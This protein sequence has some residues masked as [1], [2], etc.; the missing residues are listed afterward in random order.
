V[1]DEELRAGSGETLFVFPGAGGAARELAG[2]ARVLSGDPRVIALVPLPAPDD[3]GALTTVEAMATTA[4]ALIRSHQPRGPYRLLGYSLGGIVALEAGQRL[5]E[6]GEVVSF[7]GLVDALYD[8]RYWPGTLFIRASA[9][10]SA[11]HVRGLFGKPP[12]HAWHE[13]RERGG[14]LGVRL[15]GRFNDQ[16]IDDN[17]PGLTVQ[18]ANLV[19]MSRWRPRVFEG[20]IVFFTADDTDFGCDLADV[21]RPWLPGMQVR[22]I[23]GKH[24]DLVHDPGGMDRLAKTV[25]E[26]L[27]ASTTPRLH[28]LVATTFR[29]S[30]AARLAVELSAAGCKVE[31]VAPRGS[32]L[33]KIA[34]V[35]GSYALGLIDAA[36][37]L[38][39][40]IESSSADLI[41]PFD[42]RT[43]R[44]L[45]RVYADADP[46][47][48]AGARLRGRLERSLGPP[49]L[50]PRLYS[51]V[52]I[53]DIAAECGLRCPPTAAVRSAADVT[54]WL[55]RHPGPAVLKTDGSWGGRE[56][57][58]IRTE[59]DV[60]KA[61]RQLSRPPAIAR[62]VKRALLERD[63]WP[64]RARLTG[65]RPRLSVQSYVEGAPG[66]AAVACLDGELLGAVQA[67]VV[68]SNGPT[69]PSTVLRIVEHPEMLEAARAIVDRLQMSGLAGLDFILENG[70]GRA[71]LIEVN[72]RATPTS[73]LI[74]AEG[75]DL[76][77]SLR[78]AL[79]YA[80]PAPRTGRYPDGRVA[81]FPQEMERDPR[82]VLVDD[83]YHDVPWHAPDLL[84][85]ALCDVRSSRSSAMRA[86][87]GGLAGTPPA[88]SPL[89]PL[90]GRRD[91]SSNDLLDRGQL[92]A[93]LATAPAN[94][95]PPAAG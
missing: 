35:E 7:L 59:A 52:A 92:A 41:I 42:D 65:Y 64:L 73:H 19:V 89:T 28:T 80:G 63:P 6:D 36:G 5:R 18:Q 32:A 79:G 3:T 30:C 84:E 40:A 58:V 53:M 43:R 66:N 77:A 8:R 70:T 46:T 33:H 11:V 56:T 44:A 72:P 85:L 27:A 94:G 62:C 57:R 82:S 21:W 75:I 95:R 14:R 13:L 68:Q 48:E 47:T 37:S 74:S 15:L 49:D 67:E 60:R 83:A 76:L 20:R 39:R 2:L 45:H 25:D 23:P 78:S 24:L 90:M 34:A 61:W 9:R 1:I 10:R 50:Y 88:S 69:G 26:A 38:R 12:A 16:G 4:V 71:H 51:R 86:R 17:P 22:R 81:L 55:V 29:W 87:L 31:A 91:P 54:E 93:E